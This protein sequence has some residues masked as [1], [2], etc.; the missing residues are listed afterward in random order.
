MQPAESKSARLRRLK[1]KLKHGKAPEVELDKLL[2]NKN[3]EEDS[4]S[5][6]EDEEDYEDKK[7]SDKEEEIDTKEKSEKT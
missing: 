3:D 2:D 4:E 6:T 5:E 1:E 7:Q